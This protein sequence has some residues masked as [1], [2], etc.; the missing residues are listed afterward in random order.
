MLFYTGRR[1]T[2]DGIFIIHKYFLA[3][4]G[5]SGAE[6]VLTTTSR[7]FVDF[8]SDIFPNPSNIFSF[9]LFAMI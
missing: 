4:T 9:F 1:M 3:E 2:I 5:A 6:R 8:Q 7:A